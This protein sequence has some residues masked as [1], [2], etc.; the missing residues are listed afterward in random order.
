MPNL[1][2][3]ITLRGTRT[4]GA[5]VKIEFMH[6]LRCSETHLIPAVV[7]AHMGNLDNVQ[8]LRLKAKSSY[9]GN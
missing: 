8:I 4:F 1:F 6:V 2:K 3:S 9:L 5:V 7:K